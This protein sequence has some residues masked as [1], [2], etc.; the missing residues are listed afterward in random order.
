[1][2]KSSPRKLAYQAERQKSPE[3]VEKRVDRNRA[4]RHAEAAGL[5]HK[6]DG[7]EIDHRVPLDKGGSDKDS[8]TRVISAKENRAWRERQP[9]M[10]GKGKKK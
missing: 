8:N 5:V 6:G 7:K 9:E 10:Y 4:R 3:E 2:P 1:M